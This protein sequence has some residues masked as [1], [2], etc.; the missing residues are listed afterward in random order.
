MPA[1]NYVE[2]GPAQSGAPGG[3]QPEGPGEQDYVEFLPFAEA[4]GNGPWRVDSSGNMT[5]NGLA[6]LKG[7]SDTSATASSPSFVSGTSL[8]LNTTQD[9]MLY[10]AITTS[11]ALA[12][13]IGPTAGV[14]TALIPSASYALS[15]IS[16]RVPKGW[17]VKITGTIAD[18]TITAITC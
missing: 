5:V 14:A 12:V 18:A 11:A 9:T 17:F 15:V 16:I 3:L 8:Q 13:A 4:S 7:G 2:T 6:A 1:W 10:I